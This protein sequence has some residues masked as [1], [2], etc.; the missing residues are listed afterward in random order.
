M[1]L[2]NHETNRLLQF[3][4][5]IE[6]D[7]YPEKPS[8]LHTEITTKAVAT[9]LEAFQLRKKAK[10]L[11][12]GCGQAPALQIFTE[13]GFI[14]VGITLDNEDLSVCQNRGFTVAKMD[15]SF[16]LFDAET[17]DLIWARHVL[18]H[19][20][21]PL[22]T[23]SGFFDVLRENGVLYVEVPAPDTSCHH[24]RNP[25]HYSVLGKSAWVS[26]IERC[27]FEIILAI[28][29]SFMV[30]AGPDEYWGFYCRKNPLHTS[31]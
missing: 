30:I 6:H 14:P 27:G 29:Y 10:V 8:V 18:E 12:V 17:F 25:N 7:V 23:L 4:E 20:I 13:K 22:F 3:L 26:L 31:R 1:A 24:E 5:K 11:D 9:L 15:Q 19:S 28:S 16:L 2:P 21:Y